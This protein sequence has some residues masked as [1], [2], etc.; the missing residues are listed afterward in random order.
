MNFAD[1]DFI[2]ELWAEKHNA[3]TKVKGLSDLSEKAKIGE[4][5]EHKRSRGSATSERPGSTGRQPSLKVG[6]PTRNLHYYRCLR[7]IYDILS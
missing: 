6:K 5:S 2:D 1:A 4:K 3:V 7:F